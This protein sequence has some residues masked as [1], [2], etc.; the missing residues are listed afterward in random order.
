MLYFAYCTL[1]DVEEMRRYCPT[2][3]PTGVGRL[4]GYGLGFATY[5]RED[6]GGGCN[7]ER[8][9]TKETLGLLYEMSQEAMAALDAI[10]GVD[11]GY[12]E[13]IDVTVTREDGTETPAI[14]YVI[15]EPGGPFQP[16]AAYTRPIL[17]GARA[18]QL[19][20]AYTA[21]LE[22]IIESAQRPE[23]GG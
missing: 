16:S 10:A 4:P 23:G 14:T 20:A 1:L 8:S 7:L 21:S 3:E 15:P 2:A 9:E 18:L 17:A 19:P 12:Y 11:R 5:G 22:A 6:P 13:K